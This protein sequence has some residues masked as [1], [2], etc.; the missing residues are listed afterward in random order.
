MKKLQYQRGR[1]S[2]GRCGHITS[3][4]EGEKA[5]KD[6]SLIN[7]LLAII[8]GIVGL[9]S[10]SVVLIADSIHSFSD[11]VASI[12]V[13]IGL[14]LSKRKPD[15]KFL[16]GYYRIETVGSLLVSVMIVISG[17]EIGLESYNIFLYPHII[18]IPL[19]ALFVAAISGLISFVLARYKHDVGTKI[20]SQSLIS[21]GKHSYLDIFSSIIVFVGIFFTFLG[22]LRIQGI[23]GVV[24]AFLIIFIGLKLAKNDFMV[25][26][27]ANLDPEKINEI[28]SIAE[29]ID[30]V[31][32]AYGIKIRRSGTFIFAELHIEIKKGI[33]VKKASEI[34]LN[35]Q[36]SV[37]NRIK[38]LDNLIVQIEPNIGTKFSVAVP[39][40]NKNGLESKISKHLARAP[41]ILIADLDHGKI[42]N[43]VITENPG[44]K[45]EKKKGIKTA[46]FWSEKM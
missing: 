39:V 3:L 38:N 26:I 19:I 6:S 9:L 10:G 31:E 15:E 42:V 21:D 1:L 17:L 2:L 16:Y 35:L 34:I 33:T 46:D 25:L 44:S 22:Y 40:I 12:T 32:G 27:D 20:G 7:L 28:R 30:G 45:I 29:C 13:Y 11:I 43:N 8:K 14:K 5:A 24:V 36:I 37:K 41:Y 23:A 18:K 4:Q